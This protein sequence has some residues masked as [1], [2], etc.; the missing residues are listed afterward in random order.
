[1]NLIWLQTWMKI[2]KEKFLSKKYNLNEIIKIN[3][4]LMLILL[5]LNFKYWFLA[6]ANLTKAKNANIKKDFNIKL[7]NINLQKV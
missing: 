2:K 1:M 4:L 5:F 3:N 6:Y 7:N